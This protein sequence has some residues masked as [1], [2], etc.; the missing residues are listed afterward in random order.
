MIEEGRKS[1]AEMIRIFTERV[2]SP[3][4]L[5][6]E[7]EGWRFLTNCDKVDEYGYIE[8]LRLMYPEVKVL[9]KAYAVDGKTQ[10]YDSIGVYVRG[11]PILKI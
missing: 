9:D 8:S 6:L 4:E 11:I 3:L 10:F 1:W 5:E 2:K 7:K